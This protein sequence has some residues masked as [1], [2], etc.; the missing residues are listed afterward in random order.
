MEDVALD[1]LNNSLNLSFDMWSILAGIL[2]GAVGLYVFRHG[3]RESD[4]RNVVFGLLLM[5][6]PYFVDGAKL[7]W[8]IGM[9]LC[10]AVYY[11]W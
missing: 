6:Y 8:A 1:S 11:Y 10:G 9:A 2:F 4:I 7:T 5:I 3:R